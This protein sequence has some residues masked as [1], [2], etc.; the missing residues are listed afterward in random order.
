M[1]FQQLRDYQNLFLETSKTSP[2]GRAIVCFVCLPDSLIP[3]GPPSPGAKA[4]RS[5][6]SPTPHALRPR[7]S[8]SVPSGVGRMIASHL[9]AY[10]LR[11]STT[12]SAQKV[13]KGRLAR[14]E[15]LTFVR[16]S[17]SGVPADSNLLRPGGWGPAFSPFWAADAE[18]TRTAGKAR[19]GG[20]TS[21]RHRSARARLRGSG[22]R[23]LRASASPRPSPSALRSRF[24]RPPFSAPGGGGPPRCPSL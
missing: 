19:A 7:A 18:N 4:V 15:N 3:A 5:P 11:S 12:T 21:A 1:V 2:A 17:L 24:P 14:L 16:G 6:H 23:A 8:S 10:F 22:A 20:A 9:L 13:S